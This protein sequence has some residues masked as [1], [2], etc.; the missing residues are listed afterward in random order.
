MYKKYNARQLIFAVAAGFFLCATVSM[1]SDRNY[2]WAM[3]YG[4][5]TLLDTY[6]VLAK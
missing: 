1:L 3:I 5:M 4:G 6:Y 2:S